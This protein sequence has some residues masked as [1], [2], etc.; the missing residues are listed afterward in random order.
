M[1]CKKT[2]DNKFFDCPP[3]M[4]DGRHFTDYSP[5]CDSE[6][7]IRVTNG[8][9]SSYDYRMFLTQNASHI[10]DINRSS[11]AQKGLCSDCNGNTVPPPK[12]VQVCDTSKCTFI[13]GRPD[14]IGLVIKSSDF[15][16]AC[17]SVTAP[18]DNAC[19][20]A[21]QKNNYLPVNGDLPQRFASP[22]GGTPYRGGDYLA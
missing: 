13:P 10:M 17:T 8:L 22:G 2:S 4:D 20:T 14:G 7:K 21:T 6:N 19:Y 11:V 3:R 1:D 18:K 15:G 5:S 12:V 9:S 16:S